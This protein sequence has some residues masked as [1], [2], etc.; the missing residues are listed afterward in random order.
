MNTCADCAAA[1]D[2]RCAYHEGRLTARHY[3]AAIASGVLLLGAASVILPAKA[4]AA[5]AEV[6]HCVDRAEWR[7][8]HKDQR[9]LKV[10]AITGQVG[11][12]T[13]MQFADPSIDRP[14]MQM[15][16]FRTCG[17]LGEAGEVWVEFAQNDGYWEVEAK[18]THD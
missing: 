9:W 4:D 3:V 16:A 13:W 2:K 14:A 10:A 11:K 15:R 1:C 5:P 17:S 12:R 18:H 6:R 8:I 7:T